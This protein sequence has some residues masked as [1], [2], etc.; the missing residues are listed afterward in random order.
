MFGYVKIYKDELKIK[1]WNR[2]RAYYCALCRGIASY[3]QLHRLLLSYDMTFLT[4]LAGCDIDTAFCCRNK[5]QPNCHGSVGCFAKCSGDSKLQF[6]SAFSILL[7]YEKIKDDVIDGDR[8]KRLFIPLLKKGYFKAK[9]TYPEMATIVEQQMQRL[10]ALE[11]ND[12][13]DLVQLQECFA[14]IF[15]DVFRHLPGESESTQK[16]LGEIVYHV[17]AWV[18]LIDMYDD[19]EKDKIDNNFNPLL[20]VNMRNDSINTEELML[21][22]LA[23]HIEQ[24]KVQL[25]VLPYSDGTA[26]LENILCWGLPAQMQKIGLIE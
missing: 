25:Q 6:L 17:A 9:D 16:I 19:Q 22:L 1:D 21:G 5:A 14:R 18:Y 15:K 4:I 26:I 20:H 2:Y 11:L 8:K 12:C 23:E 24:A 3:S 13:T 10:R 7:Q